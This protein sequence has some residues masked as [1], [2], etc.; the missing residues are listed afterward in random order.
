M[1]QG[2]SEVQKEEM[3][4]ID[5]LYHVLI[6]ECESQV[7]VK[8]ERNKCYQSLREELKSI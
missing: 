8:L 7:D 6:R 5:G 2:E 4:E 3:M 1:K